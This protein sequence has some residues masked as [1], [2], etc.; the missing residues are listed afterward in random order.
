VVAG[1]GTITPASGS[2]GPAAAI[3]IGLSAGWSVTLPPTC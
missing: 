1:L 3:V 2:V